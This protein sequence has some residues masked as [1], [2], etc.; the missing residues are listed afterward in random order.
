MLPCVARGKVAEGVD[1][2]QDYGRAIL[3]IWI[4]IQCTWD[5]DPRALLSFMQVTLEMSENEFLTLAAMGQ[6]A[7]CA[8][9]IIRN[10][11]DYGVVVLADNRF[12]RADRRTKLT[13]WI[14]NLLTDS[15][16]DVNATEAASILLVYIRAI[17]QVPCY[18]AGA[19]ILLDEEEVKEMAM[20]R[21]K[22][23]QMQF[24]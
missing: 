9:R 10:K 11:N 23:Q 15:H 12:A 19:K 20:E 7:K 5:I 17:N 6:T 3:I 18:D 8:G 2:E 24:V 13:Q 21:M 4:L 1:F 14:V 22:Q 16:A